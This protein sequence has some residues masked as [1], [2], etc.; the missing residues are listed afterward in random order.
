[1]KTYIV[2]LAE[3]GLKQVG[4]WFYGIWVAVIGLANKKNINDHWESHSIKVIEEPVNL[5]IEVRV[6]DPFV[7]SIRTNAGVF[8]SVGSVEEEFVEVDCTD[9]LV[10]HDQF[11][12]VYG[13]DDGLPSGRGREFVCRRRGCTWGLGKRHETR[14][15]HLHNS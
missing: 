6:Y 13:E 3:K 7:S 5:G 10:D 14:I 4:T 1:M 11:L 9:F 8:I 2:S 15:H 12:R